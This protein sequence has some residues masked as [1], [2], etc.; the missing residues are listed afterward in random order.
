VLEPELFGQLVVVD[1]IGL[2]SARGKLR[3][4]EI[5]AAGMILLD[6]E[7]MGLVEGMRDAVKNHS[8]AGQI[9][10][11]GRAEMSAFWTDPMTQVQCKCRPDYIRADGIIPDLKSAR[12]ASP[13]GFQKAAWD[14][15]YQMQAAF[16]MDGLRA[17]GE[18]AKG[19]LFVV[20]EN[21]PPHCVAVYVADE[22]LLWYGRDEYQRA[23]QIY[24]DLPEGEWPGYPEEVLT[25]S[26]PSWVKYK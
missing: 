22:D 13:R 7:S 24:A 14:A 21:T 19:F 18:H 2:Q 5:S 20:V 9:F 1:N 23:L 17:C 3:A 8:I 15:G 10:H 25:L 12:D 16:Y 4:A 6:D 11:G 26:P